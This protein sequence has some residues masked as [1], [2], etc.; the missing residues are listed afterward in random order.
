MFYFIRKE[1]LPEEEKFVAL[2]V[3]N[4]ASNKIKLQIENKHTNT[5]IVF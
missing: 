4:H 1:T 5:I 2:L 3:Q